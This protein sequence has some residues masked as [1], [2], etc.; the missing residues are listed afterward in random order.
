MLRGFEQRYHLLL[1]LAPQH[2]GK[3][4]VIVL[5][6]PGPFCSHRLACATSVDRSPV[7]SIAA[8]VCQYGSAAR[9]PAAAT[10]SALRV[11]AGSAIDNFASLPNDPH[12]WRNKQPGFPQ[13]CQ[14]RPNASLALTSA[15]IARVR[16]VAQ[17]RGQ[18]GDRMGQVSIAAPS[19]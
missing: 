19:H 3:R 7:S 4:L 18:L 14:Y 11:T 15:R 12:G 10:A 9:Q 5:G 16:R 8:S 6:K 1:A 2:I 17:G 13:C